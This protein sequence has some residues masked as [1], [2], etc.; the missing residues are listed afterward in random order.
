MV[1]KAYIKA[2]H[3][4]VTQADGTVKRLEFEEPKAKMIASGS[5][6]FCQGAL[7]R[8]QE[9][10]PGTEGGVVESTQNG[11]LWHNDWRKVHTV[12]GLA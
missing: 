11:D 4:N 5:E 8:Y 12:Q 6:E 1:H 10:H 3:A 7:E 2:S 9:K